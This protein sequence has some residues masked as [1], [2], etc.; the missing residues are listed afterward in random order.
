MFQR[1]LL[2]LKTLRRLNDSKGYPKA[3][4]YIKHTLKIFRTNKK[5]ILRFCMLNHHAKF[6]KFCTTKKFPLFGICSADSTKVVYSRRI[7][8]KTPLPNSAQQI[9]SPNQRL[10]KETLQSV[11]ISGDL[12]YALVTQYPPHDRDE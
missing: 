9:N 4:L 1:F 10:M 12:N 6:A 7:A 11:V 2:V 8:L 3:K 5:S